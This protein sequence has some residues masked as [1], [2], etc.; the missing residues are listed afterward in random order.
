[1]SFARGDSRRP[2][3]GREGR[4]RRAV[5]FD[6]APKSQD[7]VWYVFGLHL[8]ASSQLPIG[9]LSDSASVCPLLRTSWLPDA[10]YPV[11]RSPHDEVGGVTD[12][13]VVQVERLEPRAH[14]GFG[15]ADG[16]PVH[17]GDAF[18]H[19]LPGHRVEP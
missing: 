3:G 15:Q 2:G 1:M 18:R 19:G 8:S 4:A 6:G 14:L 5:G 11:Q 13:L 16:P 10:G 9:I 17:V 7:T 12:D